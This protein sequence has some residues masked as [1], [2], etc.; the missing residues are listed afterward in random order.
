M[1]LLLLPGVPAAAAV[2]AAAASPLLPG[3][4]T[5][6]GLHLASE[7]TA[8][9]TRNTTSVLPARY[10]FAD[11]TPDARDSAKRIIHHLKAAFSEPAVEAQLAIEVPPPAAPAA[12]G[13]EAPRQPTKWEFYCQ[14]N[15]SG[16]A[17]LAVLKAC[18]E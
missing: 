7:G 3:F 17:A 16:S 11:N 18:S 10:L 12:E 2:A 13:E 8:F 6:A 14:S 15:L 1:L 5:E 4:R 9:S